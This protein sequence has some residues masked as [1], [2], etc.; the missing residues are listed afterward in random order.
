M[1]EPKRLQ[2][3]KA[4]APATGRQEPARGVG[5]TRDSPPPTVL[6]QPP[7][8]VRT[9]SG[10]LCPQPPDKGEVARPTPTVGVS[11]EPHGRA[12]R[13]GQPG[14]SGQVGCGVGGPAPRACQRRA[15]GHHEVGVQAISSTA[16]GVQASQVGQLLTFSGRRTEALATAQLARGTWERWGVAPSTQGTPSVKRGGLSLRTQ[17]PPGLSPRKGTHTDCTERLWGH[18]A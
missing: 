2:R 9:T 3:G 18:L 7:V 17:G 16:G 8:P 14:G 11:G 4:R 15:P 12:A 13:A 10:P 6:P 1:R 5:P